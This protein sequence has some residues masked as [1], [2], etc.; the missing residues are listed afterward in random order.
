MTWS[1]LKFG[2]HKGRTLPQVLFQDP[3]WFFWAVENDKFLNEI[4]AAEAREL[5]RKATA[6]C[7]PQREKEDLVAEYYIHSPTGKFA[8]LK[9]VP[10]SRPEHE[11]ASESFRSDTIN[12]LTP[13]QIYPFDKR[14]SKKL[15]GDLKYYFFGSSSY[16]MTKR[17]C[18]EFFE[19]DSNFVL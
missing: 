11:G 3:D 15:I 9:L 14:G 2:K 19:D 6:I 16:K 8:Q 1:I 18:E 17:R 10:R 12:L 13:R 4:Q 7:I 5:Y